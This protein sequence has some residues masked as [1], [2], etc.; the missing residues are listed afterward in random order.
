MASLD[1]LPNG[2][3]VSV[4]QLYLYLTNVCIYTQ[5]NSNKL[6]NKKKT[7]VYDILTI[8]QDVTFLFLFL[9]NLFHYGSDS[10]LSIQLCNTSNG[11][12]GII[13]I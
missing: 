1:Q 10:P 2:V 4:W 9:I 12:N 5:L 11:N 7:I 13:Y 3:I 6:D 8:C